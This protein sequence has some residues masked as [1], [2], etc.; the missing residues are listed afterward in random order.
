MNK[1]DPAAGP[2]STASRDTVASVG[3]GHAGPLPEAQ[4]GHDLT[5][6][7]CIPDS[8]S[9][10]SSASQTPNTVSA[11]NAENVV[12]PKASGPPEAL[13]EGAIK[14]ALPEAIQGSIPDGS[15][16]RGESFE[17]IVADAPA[18]AGE[19]TVLGTPEEAVTPPPRHE[20]EV[21]TPPPRREVRAVTPPPR[22]ESVAVTPPPRREAQTVTPPPRHELQ[23]V[24]PPPR[25]E[26]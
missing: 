7:W 19:A 22:H 11:P 18:G 26:M 17:I 1:N 5:L 16:P 8:R 23:A 9:K 24:T 14:G 4:Q 21:V 10:A 15:S 20:M 6:K 13:A 2:P 12:T 3:T 25:H